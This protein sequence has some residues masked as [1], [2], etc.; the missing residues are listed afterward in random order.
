[1]AGGGGESLGGRRDACAAREGR[2]VGRTK[3]AVCALRVAPESVLQPEGVLA[4][5]AS[6]RDW[7]AWHLSATGN[8]R[9][10]GQYALGLW[11]A[12][13]ALPTPQSVRRN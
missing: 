1:M 11:R 10:R 9:V 4:A 12:T 13:I 8:L 7:S 3:Q 2:S 5:A 6:A